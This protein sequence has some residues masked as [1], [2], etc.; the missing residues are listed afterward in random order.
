MF[1]KSSPSTPFPSELFRG[2]AHDSGL[3]A[4]EKDSKSYPIGH[5][6]S[7][8]GKQ[9]PNRDC[10]NMPPYGDHVVFQLRYLR[11]KE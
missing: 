3:A 10:G 8:C 5:G 7:L 4:H 9:L 11:V 2:I 6:F 1:V